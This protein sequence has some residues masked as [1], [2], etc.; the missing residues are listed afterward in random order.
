MAYGIG[1]AAVDRMAADCAVELRKHNVGMISLWPG[2]VMTEH[3]AA[4]VEKSELYVD[5]DIGY[6][7]YIYLSRPL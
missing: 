3:V 6:M 2:P 1:K 7:A 4:K 5:F